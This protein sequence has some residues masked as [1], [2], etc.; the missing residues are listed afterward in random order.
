VNAIA[1]TSESE[2]AQ[3]PA[4]GWRELWLKEDWWAIWLGLGIVAAAYL[5]F[6]NWSSLKWLAVTPAKWSTFAELS[7]H[8]AHNAPRYLAQYAMWVAVF[9]LALSA[10]GYKAREFIPS[11][12][13]LYILSVL[14]FSV[15]QWSEANRYNL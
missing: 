12:T 6:A 9:T 14:I 5:L 3:A 10:L 2:R 8:F 11:F 1:T 7:D 13:L 4:P 15:G